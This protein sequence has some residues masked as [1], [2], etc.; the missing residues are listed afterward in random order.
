[1]PHTFTNREI[2]LID[3]QIDNLKLGI[4]LFLA[5]D[6]SLSASDQQIAFSTVWPIIACIFK[7]ELDAANSTLPF[8]IPK[9][10]PTGPPVPK[11]AL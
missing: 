2:T 4:D 8:T 5:Q 10:N 11:P 9:T 6:M 1:M 3:N 7:E